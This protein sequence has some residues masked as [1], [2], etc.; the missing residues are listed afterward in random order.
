MKRYVCAIM[1][2]F[3]AQGAVAAQSASDSSIA[4]VAEKMSYASPSGNDSSSAAI[5]QEK[6][7]AAPSGSEDTA[8]VKFSATVEMQADKQMFDEQSSTAT[9]IRDSHYNTIAAGYRKVVDDFWMRVDFRGLYRSKFYEGAFHLRFYPKFVKRQ[10]DSPGSENWPYLPLFELNRAYLK[11]FK[12]YAVNDAFSSEIY[13]K[14]GRDGMINS[15]SQ[16]FGNYLDQPTAG[17]GPDQ[18]ANIVGPFKN[19]IV[20]ANQIEANF[21]CN[22]GHLFASRTSVMIGASLNNDMWYTSPKPP[23][24]ERL[25]S[26]LSAGFLRLYQDFYTCHDRFHVGIGHRNYSTKRDSSDYP[27]P[28]SFNFWAVTADAVIIPDLKIYSEFG[29]QKMPATADII[30]PINLG[31]T[32][33]TGKVLDTLAIEVENVA[34]TYFSDQCLRDPIGGKM[35]TVALAWG[36]EAEKLFAKRIRVAWGL[37]TGSVNGDLKTSLRLSSFF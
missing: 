30:R 5:S 12:D 10:T 15:S 25:D 4:S 27:V 22:V 9:P 18:K 26:D 37:Y 1:A 14:V 16:L 36:I 17:Y 29:Y 21:R 34:K 31:I 6:T 13:L 28:V 32:I 8:K 24:Y 19:R 11:V 35:N 20:F 7:Q 23:I 2:L 3:M 33:P